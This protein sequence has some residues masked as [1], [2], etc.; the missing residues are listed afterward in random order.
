M[1]EGQLI[2]RKQYLIFFYVA[3]YF[4]DTLPIYKDNYL[5]LTPLPPPLFPFL[6]SSDILC[7]ISILNALCLL[8][9]QSTVRS[10]DLDM[11]D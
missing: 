3:S 6:W 5:K 11:F 4:F 9:N 1:G 2:G 8:L 10:S 7:D